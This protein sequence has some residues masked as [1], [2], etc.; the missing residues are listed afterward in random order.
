MDDKETRG[1][2]DT[3]EDSTSDSGSQYED[4]DSSPEENP[5]NSSISISNNS[6]PSCKH[7]TLNIRSMERLFIFSQ[8]STNP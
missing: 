5:A 8:V 2:K 6:V 1:Y 7:H 4:C 3:V